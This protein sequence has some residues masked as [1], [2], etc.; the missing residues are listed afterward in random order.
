MKILEEFLGCVVVR[1]VDHFRLDRIQ[2]GCSGAHVILM[3]MGPY[4]V[5]YHS[6]R[7]VFL[8]DGE[9]EL[10]VGG[11]PSVYYHGVSVTDDQLEISLAYIDV[12]DV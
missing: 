10:S 2:D 1:T 3:C 9:Y 7:D 6:V 4:V 5:V 8:E 12:I 11:V